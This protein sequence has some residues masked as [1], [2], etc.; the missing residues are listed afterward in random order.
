MSFADLAPTLTFDQAEETERFYDLAGVREFGIAGT[1]RMCR[2]LARVDPPRARKVAAG[3][4]LPG[5]RVCAWAFVAL[6]LA[7][8]DPAGSRCARSCDPRNRPAAGTGYERRPWDRSQRCPGDLSDQSG[9]II[10][11]VVER[12][13]L[14]R[15]PDFFW[16]VALHPQI[17]AD[18]DDL[19]WTSYIGS[20][21]MLLARY[22]RDVAAVMFAQMDSYL[23]A[24]ARRKS[25]RGEYNAAAI[26]GKS[27]ID[28]KAAVALLDALGLPERG[29]SS[30]NTART[31]LAEALGQPAA[32]RWKSRFRH[33]LGA[34]L[35]LDD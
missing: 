26:T 10:L 35:P 22:D 16:P 11:P 32:E 3:F 30:S 21:C 29:M 13:A 15:L 19:L 34:Q 14:D 6:G 17:D 7:E 5:E 24:L 9:R 12:V 1:M 28:P 2:R 20:E 8:K 4:R 18:H 25:D 31:Y 27:C 33:H 23:Q